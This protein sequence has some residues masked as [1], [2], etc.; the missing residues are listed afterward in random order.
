MRKILWYNSFFAN[1]N[2]KLTR[3]VITC[4]RKKLIS[5]T[6]SKIIDIDEDLLIPNYKYELPFISNVVN[7]YLIEQNL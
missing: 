3:V 7:N 2:R 6:Y 1:K 5:T 4:K